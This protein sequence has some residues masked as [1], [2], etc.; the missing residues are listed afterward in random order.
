M[1]GIQDNEPRG[2]TGMDS[3]RLSELI[4]YSY[5]K[6]GLTEQTKYIVFLSYLNE[7]SLLGARGGNG[8]GT[9][10]HWVQNFSSERWKG[11]FGVTLW[12]CSQNNGKVPGPGLLR[13]WSG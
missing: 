2:F 12:R 4:F 13:R 10:V 3:G 7:W 11:G 6:P 1:W 5:N 8:D 9:V